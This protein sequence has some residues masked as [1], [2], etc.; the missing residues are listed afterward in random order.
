M[1]A[2]L[3]AGLA[4]AAAAILGVTLL[5]MPVLAGLAIW[6]AS[7][8]IAA[9]LSVAATLLGPSASDASEADLPHL[10]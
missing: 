7:G 9:L 3:A 6:G 5:G 10:A 8:P 2:V 4:G 1:I